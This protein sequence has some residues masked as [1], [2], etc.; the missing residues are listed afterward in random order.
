MGELLITLPTEIRLESRT[1]YAMYGTLKSS[2][3]TCKG[4]YRST[5]TGNDY[6]IVQQDV[7]DTMTDANFTVRVTQIKNPSTSAPTSEILV[8]SQRY[9]SSGTDEDGNS[10]AGWYSIEGTEDLEE[11]FTYRVTR[12]SD[13][14]R[15]SVKR[16]PLDDGSGYLAGNPTKV[17]VELWPLKDIDE[18]AA[19][20]V[21]FPEGAQLALNPKPVSTTCYAA[22]SL[23]AE[24]DRVY[25]ETFPAN[26][27]VIV[28]NYCFAT[29]ACTAKQPVVRFI[30]S[31]DFIINYPLVVEPLQDELHSLNVLI[32]TD[33]T[34]YYSGQKNTKIFVEPRLQPNALIFINPEIIRTNSFI[35]SQ[36]SWVINFK[37]NTNAV[38]AGGSLQLAVPKDVMMYMGEVPLVKNYTNEAWT[39][40]P[41]ISFTLHSD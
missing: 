25:C 28:R 1:C 5:S 6:L 15:V 19:F 7:F 16:F 34:Y 29:D 26:R 17:L 41:N 36:T 32:S 13:I 38:E 35:N 31:N 18:Q 9:Y 37:T 27:T 24:I 3:L 21:Q 40:V 23:G 14:R 4:Y 22:T 30:M 2:K 39:E 12:V 8:L 33:K 20:V 10:I 11:G